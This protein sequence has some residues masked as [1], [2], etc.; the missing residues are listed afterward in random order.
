ME[1]LG[2]LS[3]EKLEREEEEATSEGPFMDDSGLVEDAEEMG[4]VSQGALEGSVSEE[5]EDDQKNDDKEEDANEERKDEDEEQDQIPDEDDTKESSGRTSIIKKTL[6]KSLSFRSIK[7]N[8]NKLC[9]SD[10]F[11][12]CQKLS[13]NT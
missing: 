11:V 3:G 6:F 9:N 4:R 5:H 12:I 8:Q 2:P 1:D 10:M 7:P 13:V